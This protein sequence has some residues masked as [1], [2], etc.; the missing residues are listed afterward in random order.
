MCDY[1]CIQTT[2]KKILTLQT[3]GELESE[4]P[5]NRFCRVH[6]SYIVTLDKI[7]RI[8]RNRIKIGNK[9]IPISETYKDSFYHLIGLK[10]SERRDLST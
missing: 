4:L 10:H 3:F 9:L 6:K 8:E 5:G 1:R 2:S 7:D